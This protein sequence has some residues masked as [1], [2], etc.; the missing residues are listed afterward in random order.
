M[1]AGPF[2][3]GISTELS[4]VSIALGNNTVLALYTLGAEART[5]PIGIVLWRATRY[6]AL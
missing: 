4:L 5:E 6:Q 1:A 2:G 3:K